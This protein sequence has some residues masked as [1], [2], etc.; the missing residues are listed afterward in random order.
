[1][2]RQ[3]KDKIKVGMTRSQVGNEA[4]KIGFKYKDSSLA[5][6]DYVRKTEN[7]KLK[8]YNHS[9]SYYF[10]GVLLDSVFHIDFDNSSLVIAITVD[11]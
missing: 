3:F 7:E 4:N 2:V 5:S 11:H 10:A 9:E 1:M 6:T 8:T